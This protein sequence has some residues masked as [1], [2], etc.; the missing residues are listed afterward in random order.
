MLLLIL[1]ALASLAPS[2]AQND[3]TPN[4]LKAMQLLYDCTA[5]DSCLHE[6]TSDLLST[7]FNLGLIGDA[8]EVQRKAQATIRA[9]NT[10]LD[11]VIREKVTKNLACVRRDSTNANCVVS[12][13]VMSLH[14]KRYNVVVAGLEAVKASIDVAPA[15]LEMMGPLN[16]VVAGRAG[17]PDPAAFD[18]TLVIAYAAKLA[19]FQSGWEPTQMLLAVDGGFPVPKGRGRVVVGPKY[20]PPDA[21]QHRDEVWMVM[22]VVYVACE[23]GFYQ[24]PPGVLSK[25]LRHLVQSL[26][27]AMHQ[28]DTEMAGEVL[29]CLEVAGS[30]AVGQT[31]RTA[32]AKAREWLV[33]QQNPDGSW[34]GDDG[35]RIH[36]VYV[37]A[38]GL[39][40]RGPRQPAS[41]GSAG[42]APLDVGRHWRIVRQAGLGAGLAGTEEL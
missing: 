3:Y 15:L 14:A 30:V 12:L 22:H 37:A 23:F 1:V 2:Q 5:D 4:V 41:H 39:T 28:G 40:G 27:P 26:E 16:S 17:K 13:I 9:Q 6:N 18:S 31:G 21:D 38:L 36:R 42:F 25:E 35:D 20:L 34:G 8:P 24:L 32:V 29:D 7:W 19:G 11:R 10:A 33:G